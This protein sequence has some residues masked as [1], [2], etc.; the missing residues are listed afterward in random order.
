M[1]T[2]T[3]RRSMHINAYLYAGWASLPRVMKTGYGADIILSLLDKYPESKWNS[4]KEGRDAFTAILNGVPPMKSPA[5][6]LAQAR[7]MCDDPQDVET[8]DNLIIIVDDDDE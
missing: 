7:E 6:Y 8:F 4:S 1:D 2:A 3:T 5:Y